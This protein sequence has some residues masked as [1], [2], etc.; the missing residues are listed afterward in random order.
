MSE[1]A[2]APSSMRSWSVKETWTAAALFLGTV[3]SRLPFRSQILYHWDSVNFAFAM[4]RFDVAAE[5]PHSPGYIAYVW[6]CRLVDTLFQDPQTTMVWLSVVG[7]GVAAV[8][9]YLLGRAMFDQRTGLVGALFLTTSPLFWFY[10]EIALPHAVDTFVV[11]LSAWLLYEVTLGWVWAVMPAAVSLA[12]AGGV[13][14][15]TPVFLALLAL[16]AGVR[17]LQR[18]GWRRGGRWGVLAVAVFGLLCAGW[19]L[20]LINSTGGPVHYLQVVG[21]FSERFDRTTSIFLGAGMGG[22]SRNLH[23]LASAGFP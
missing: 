12:I 15:Q 16:F 3:L 4:Q 13:R 11:I 21:A 1:P 19:F 2:K 9:M 6:L 14:Q 18:V 20:P 23:K 8:A 10:G 22:L 17:F 5:Q 7:S